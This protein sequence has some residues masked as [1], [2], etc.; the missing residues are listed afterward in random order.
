MTNPYKAPESDVSLG[1]EEIPNRTGW[2]VF[3][4]IMLALESWS[5]FSMLGDPEETLFNILGEGVV[6]T[7]I[8][9]GLFGFSHNKKLL[10]QQFWG[11]LI[12]VGIV[13][14]V[15]TIFGMDDPGF[16]SQTELY[17]FLGFIVI[18]LVPLLLLTYLALYKYRFHSP[19]IWR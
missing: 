14:D 16:E 7:L 17:V 12:P 8:L 9:L 4:W 2:K 1:I 18:L 11:Y 19:H 5:M 3:F 6:Y 13:W 15:Y 10:S